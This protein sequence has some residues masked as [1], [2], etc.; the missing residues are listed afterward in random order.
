MTDERI[1]SDSAYLKLLKEKAFLQSRIAM[2]QTDSIYLT[3]NFADS[4][5][6]LEI[7][8]VVVH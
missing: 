2:A 8:G 4:S 5:A 7:S 3:L 1:Y 6:N